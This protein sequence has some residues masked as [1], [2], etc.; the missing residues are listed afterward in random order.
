M[1][2]PPVEIP[3]GAIRFN[4]ESA[5]LE[6][7]NGEK[8][9]Q[10]LTE[11]TIACA[12]RGVQVGDETGGPTNV[13][14]Y[15]SM[16]TMG[17]AVDFGDMQNGVGAC[18]AA[19]SRIRGIKFGGVTTYPGTF[20]NT[21]DYITIATAGNGQNFGD[22][23]TTRRA[24][25]SFGDATRGGIAG[26]ASPSWQA[27]QTG[28]DYV[29]IS[30]EGNTQDFGD[31]SS[32]ASCN[33]SSQMGSRT[34]GLMVANKANSP[35]TKT[36]TVEYITV[37]T[38]GNSIDFGD[39]T[40]APANILNGSNSTR[41]LIG[42]GDTPTI[43]NTI[44]YMQIQSLGNAVDFGDMTFTTSEASAFSSPLRVIWGDSSQTVLDAST[45]ASKGNAV[46]WGNFTEGKNHNSAL[47]NVHGGVI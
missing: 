12:G 3:L 10:V 32:A 25:Y 41:A 38:T 4:S 7:F 43:L 44:Q 39:L 29:T 2:L 47:T 20:T 6:Y 40:N 14:E 30:S 33:G 36:N 13:M 1:S 11:E 46:H 27:S 26:G 5:K 34:R 23:A 28:I 22:L 35:S 9:M 19:A 18:G 45:I 37:Q 31:I 42:G 16:D 15:I 17:D 21:I 24:P 8:W